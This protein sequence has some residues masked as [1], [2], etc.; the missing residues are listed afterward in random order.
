MTLTHVWASKQKAIRHREALK[1]PARDGWVLKHT[2]KVFLTNDI[3]YQKQKHILKLLIFG[4]KVIFLVQIDYR[5][6]RRR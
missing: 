5:T 3:I 6:L 1:P 2:H 4:V